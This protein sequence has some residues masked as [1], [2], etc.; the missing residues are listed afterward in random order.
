MDW[1]LFNSGV[2]PGKTD[3][4]GSDNVF[5]VGSGL[6]QGRPMASFPGAGRTCL[7]SLNVL[8][9]AYGESSSAGPLAIRLKEAGYDGIAITGKSP[10][11]V[12]LWID[13]DHV[14]LRD[15][16]NLWG[17]TTFETAEMIREAA[18]SRHVVTMTIGPAGENLVRYACVNVGNRYSGRCGM[19]AVMGSKRLKAIAVRGTG[20]VE[21]A[22][23]DTFVEIARRIK[24]VIIGDPSRKL[25]AERGMASTPD[26][27]NSQGLISIKNF[28]GIG[29]PRIEEIGYEA[30]RQYYKQ[31]IHCP[32][33]C[34]VNCDRLVEIPEG[35]VYGGTQ[36]SSLQTT[37]AYNMAHLM[38]DDMNT[39]IKAFERCNAYG[40]DMH[41]WSN[42]MQW[43]IECWER[44]L[45]EREDTD[46]LE[47]RWGDG[48][49]LLESIR[50]I[51]YREG[52]FGNLLADGVALAS[53][54][55]GR[56]SEEYAMQ[57][58]GMEIDDE[59]RTAK[60]YS[61]GVLTELRGPG[62]TLGASFAD[63]DNMPPRLSKEL[64]GNEHA[65]DP[66]SYEAKPDM[67]ALTERLGAI[68]DSLGV[69]FFATMRVAPRIIAQYNMGTYAEI[70]EAATGW[71]VSEQ[72]LLKIAERIL[73]VEKAIN[74]LAGLT[75]K[76]DIPPERF[77]RPVDEGP[78]KDL[79]LDK[80]KVKAMLR[81]H[82]ELHGWDG[83]TGIPARKTLYELGLQDVFSRLEEA[84]NLQST[85]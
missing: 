71:R 7:V 76:D 68:M 82:D 69:C 55:L 16:R 26:I 58:K 56:G 42:V 19:G 29:F 66:F 3:P 1:L 12:Y 33:N 31:I 35:E 34:P 83:E 22:N 44:G 62:H 32:T 84:G 9:G 72:E 53:R 81:R 45:L 59:L 54:K 74:V 13:D 73:T 64:Y 8:T 21:V 67:V 20:S 47:L 25:I 27:D 52:K 49:L 17:R 28:T 57:I 80:N 2:S 4:L 70:I 43:A 6:I 40:L 46:K 37:P 75:R 5:L 41:A 18:R 24:H 85:G 48:P 77:F 78:F 60:G 14:E 11:P 51:S 30:V 63:F 36:V 38:I 39:V 10:K 65:G 61:L 23:T 50:R 15:A 79:S